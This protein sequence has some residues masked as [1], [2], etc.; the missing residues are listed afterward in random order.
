MFGNMYP[1]MYQ[2]CS[3]QSEDYTYM[4]KNNPYFQ[5]ITLTG[6]SSSIMESGWPRM[7]QGLTVPA[8]Y[9]DNYYINE[10]SGRV[11]HHQ[12]RGAVEGEE[13]VPW[14]DQT[15]RDFIA[16]AHGESAYALD[17]L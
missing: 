13:F 6:F 16:G 2:V 12:I 7:P 5:V 8:W 4:A 9:N 1:Y 14:T 17:G 3:L 15:V 11:Q 10:K